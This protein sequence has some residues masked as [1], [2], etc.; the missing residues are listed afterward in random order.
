[1]DDL[2]EAEIG[3]ELLLRDAAVGPQPGAQQRPE[4]LGRV[5]VDLAEAVAILVTGIHTRPARGRRSCARSPR[6]AG[7]RRHRTR[8][9]APGR[10]WRPRPR[11]SAGSPA[12]RAR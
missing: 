6:L 3:R 12:A 9:Y 5:D 2:E 1:M 4:A 7:G 8:R 10:P 11:W